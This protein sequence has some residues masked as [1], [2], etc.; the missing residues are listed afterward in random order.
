MCVCTCA[1]A[2]CTPERACVRALPRPEDRNLSMAAEIVGIPEIP[3]DSKQPVTRQEGER[4]I[5]ER[6]FLPE[7][8]TLPRA[9]VQ[10]FTR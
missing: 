8:S 10:Y 3:P 9:Q 6:G 4:P 1:A 7:S 2:T 5:R